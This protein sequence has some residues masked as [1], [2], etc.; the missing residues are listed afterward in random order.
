MDSSLEDALDE[1]GA[2]SEAVGLVET[3][4]PTESVR[5]ANEMLDTHDATSDV[6]PGRV[7]LV[8]PRFLSDSL[9]S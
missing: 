6:I 9:R 4:E 8:I 5:E 3:S 1:E 7:S 2:E